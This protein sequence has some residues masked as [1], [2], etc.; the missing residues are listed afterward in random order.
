[1]FAVN[2]PDLRPLVETGLGWAVNGRGL[3]TM[4]TVW[5]LASASSGLGRV[6]RLSKLYLDTEDA[7]GAAW[8]PASDLVCVWSVSS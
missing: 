5:S 6:S 4:A 3:V 7:A 1:M 8:N 2:V